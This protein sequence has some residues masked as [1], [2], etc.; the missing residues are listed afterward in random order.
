MHHVGFEP[1]VPA[2][3]RLQT[4]ALDRATSGIGILRKMLF[5]A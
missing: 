1:T 3:K 4:Q 5:L 2:R